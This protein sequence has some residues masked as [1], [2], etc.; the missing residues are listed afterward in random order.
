MSDNQDNEQPIDAGS[1]Q[2]IPNGYI[3]V[4]H[5]GKS[6]WVPKSW[7]DADGNVKRVEKSEGEQK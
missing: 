6:Q 4:E 7:V 2:P 1:Q 3:L 5:E